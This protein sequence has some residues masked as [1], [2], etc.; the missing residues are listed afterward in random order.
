MEEPELTK[1]TGA[2][3]RIGVGGCARRLAKELAEPKSKNFG[4]GA[5]FALANRLHA[6]A[7]LAHATPGTP[8]P[9]GFVAPTDL[10]PEH[11]RVYAAAVRGYF[12]LF[13]HVPARSA[14][15]AFDE[16]E[17]QLPD[18]G[19][20]LVGN[21]GL[22]FEHADGTC[23]L[24]RLLLGGRPLDDVDVRFAALRARPWAQERIRIVSADLLEVRIVALDVELE[25]DAA[26]HDAWLAKRVAELRAHA[27]TG[28]ARPGAEC[29]RCAFVAGCEPH[30]RR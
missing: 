27:A 28:R 17:T 9:S 5:R 23:E 15:D 26:E 6:D 16:W 1:V 14:D 25:R 12:A 2:Q 11:Q 8:N 7:R 19:V 18:H 4:S 3:L 24:R 29:A 13:G 21:V 10:E 22:P 20:R 30:G